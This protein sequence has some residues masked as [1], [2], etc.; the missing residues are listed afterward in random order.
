MNISV[1]VKNQ[2]SLQT[3]NEKDIT[4]EMYDD[5]ILVLCINFDSFYSFFWLHVGLFD[6]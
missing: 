6:L 5:A 1:K 3:T 2:T 4:V